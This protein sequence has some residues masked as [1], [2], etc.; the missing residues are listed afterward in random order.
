MK[1]EKEIQNSPERREWDHQDEI[2]TISSG[3]DD[4]LNGM[5]SMNCL[6]QKNYFTFA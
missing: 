5:K 4:C 1:R 3:D 6:F 2:H